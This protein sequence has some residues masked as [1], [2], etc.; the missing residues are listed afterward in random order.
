MWGE[1]PVY[2][3]NQLPG[4]SRARLKEGLSSKLRQQP[5]LADLGVLC[6]LVSGLL[7]ELA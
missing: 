3:S 4:P 1:R 7:I 2:L 5:E 6:L